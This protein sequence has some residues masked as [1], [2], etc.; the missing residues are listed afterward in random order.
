MIQTESQATLLLVTS[1]KSCVVLFVVVS[2]VV[3]SLAMPTETG[4]QE[5]LI[6]EGFEDHDFDGL[7]E[8][9]VGFLGL[10]ITSNRAKKGKKSLAIHGNTLMDAYSTPIKTGESIISIEFWVYIEEGGRSFSLKIASDDED[11][12]NKGPEVGWNKGFV[13]FYAADRWQKIDKFTTDKWKYVRIVADFHRNI[14]D[15]YSGD[16]RHKTKQKKGIPFRKDAANSFA[17]SISFNMET[18]EVS[19]YIDDLF[20]YEGEKPI[21]LAVDPSRKLTTMWG[22]IKRR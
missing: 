7:N 14:F 15:F 5:I 11:F 9:W 2:V 16:S 13:Y 10:E 4:A 22:H 19:G 20:V 8:F 3:L 18:M 17:T 6:Q 1:I 12:D 21:A